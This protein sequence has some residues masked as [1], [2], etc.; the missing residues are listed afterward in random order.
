MAIPKKVIKFLNK[1]KIKYQSVEHRTVYTAYDKA[2]TLRV[3]PKVIGKTLLLRIDRDLAVVLIPGNRN[4][5]KNK[6]K[7]LASGWQKKQN[8]EAA[9]RIDFVSEKLMK[10]RF[11][12][13][14]IGALPPF[15]SIWKL[16]TFIDNSLIKEKNIFVNSG[17]YE[18]S[19]KLSPRIFEKIGAIKGV[20]SQA[21]K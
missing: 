5:D 8:R 10:S 2:A 20:F 12:G 19:F 3:K 6:F 18:T 17:I 11:K 21:K 16:P 14:K 9:K 13:I 4:L 7:K 15:G 1:N